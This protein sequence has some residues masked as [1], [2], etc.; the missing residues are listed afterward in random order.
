MDS[1][2]TFGYFLKSKR[3]EREVP[4]RKMAEMAGLAP[5]YLSDIESGRRCPLDLELLNRLAKSLSLAGADRDSLFDLA[6]KGRSA[7][8][9]DLVGYINNTKT[10]RAA[11][12]LAKEKASDEDW[13]MFAFHLEAKE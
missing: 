4:I 8:P 3:K 12:R 6:G 10:A 9:P 7:A 5:G 11:L 13:Q 1:H 2:I